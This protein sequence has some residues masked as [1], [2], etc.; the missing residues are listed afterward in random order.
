MSTVTA[1][2]GGTDGVAPNGADK[3]RTRRFQGKICDSMFHIYSAA[4]PPT[5]PRTC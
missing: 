1:V 5:V 2:G 4:L 3:G